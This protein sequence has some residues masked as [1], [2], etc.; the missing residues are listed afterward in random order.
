MRTNEKLSLQQM[1]CLLEVVSPRE[2]DSL[3]G[4]EGSGEPATCVFDAITYAYNFLGTCGTIAVGTTYTD[5]ISQYGTEEFDDAI[6]L[7]M[8]G[9]KALEFSDNYFSTDSFSTHY[10]LISFLGSG[11]LMAMVSINTGPNSGHAVI[12]T[13]FDFQQN[14]LRYI[15]PEDPGA[16]DKWTSINNVDVDMMFALT[17]CKGYSDPYQ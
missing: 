12:A 6:N 7:G 15:D 1:N 14:L 9:D 10:D 4:G 5:F 16:G 13:G 11:D 3:K 8:T 2:A 17:G